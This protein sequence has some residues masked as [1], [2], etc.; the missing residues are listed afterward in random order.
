MEVVEAIWGR[1]GAQEYLPPE[2]EIAIVRAYRQQRG[3]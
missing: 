3:V 1:A 2:A